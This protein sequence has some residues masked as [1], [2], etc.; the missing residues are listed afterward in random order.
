MNIHMDR[1]IAGAVTQITQDYDINVPDSKL[2]IGKIIFKKGDSDELKQK[3]QLVCRNFSVVKK[4]RECS[5]LYINEKYDWNEI[6][7]RTLLIYKKII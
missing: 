7:N 3:L 2:D 1:K 4:F 6:L 5:S